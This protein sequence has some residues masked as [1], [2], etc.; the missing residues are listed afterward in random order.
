MSEVKMTA[1]E[2]KAMREE[3]DRLRKENA[4]MRK[5]SG[6]V[7]EITDQIPRLYTAV[8][9]GEGYIFLEYYRIISL[10]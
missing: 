1:D 7:F 2:L 3:I 9:A 8:F 5:R 10:L 6:L 4:D